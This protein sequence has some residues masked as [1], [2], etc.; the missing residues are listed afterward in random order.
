MDRRKI[1]YLDRRQIYRTWI[2]FPRLTISGKPE[3]PLQVKKS[4]SKSAPQVSTPSTER[5]AV[6]RVLEKK[7]KSDRR[8]LKG[9]I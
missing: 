2:S 9:L 8:T 6:E 1:G 5:L 4:I 7:K 3:I